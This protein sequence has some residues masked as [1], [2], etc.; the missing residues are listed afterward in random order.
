MRG[1]ASGLV[2]RPTL[3]C[4]P[5]ELCHGARRCTAH[6]WQGERAWCEQ[7]RSHSRE[8]AHNAIGAEAPIVLCAMLVFVVVYRRLWR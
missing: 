1:S 8:L 4:V 6:T 3:A 7:A 5:S 2:S